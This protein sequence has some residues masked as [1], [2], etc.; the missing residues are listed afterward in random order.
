MF[1]NNR[2]KELVRR[3]KSIHEENERLCRLVYSQ[4]NNNIELERENEKLSNEVEFL[5]DK[6]SIP[7]IFNYIVYMIAQGKNEF[8]SVRITNEED[9]TMVLMRSSYT[10]TEENRAYDY[11]VNNKEKFSGIHEIEMKNVFG[12]RTNIVS[13]TGIKKGHTK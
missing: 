12:D 13:V 11:I 9:T 4:I 3:L 5:K 10:Y 7:E 8:S 1:G 2:I 6:N